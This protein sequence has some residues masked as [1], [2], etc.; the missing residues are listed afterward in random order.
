MAQ[1]HIQI[2]TPASETASPHQ[3]FASDG[4]TA[5]DFFRDKG[6]ATPA[7]IALSLLNKALSPFGLVSTYVIFE[8]Y[9]LL[10]AHPGLW[11]TY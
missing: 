3:P 6:A 1:L 11:Q 9:L 10:Q 7:L 5:D 8:Q 2:L 4:E